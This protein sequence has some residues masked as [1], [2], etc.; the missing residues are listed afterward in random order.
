MNGKRPSILIVEDDRKVLRILT[1][2]L[3]S[4]GYAILQAENGKE[5]EDIAVSNRPDLVIL[6][7][8]LPDYDGIQ[9]LE[10]LMS[11]DNTIKVVILTGYG[12]QEIVRSAMEIGAIDF[13]TK[14]FEPDELSAV[15]REVLVSEPSA[16]R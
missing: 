11:I 16:V 5:A 4:E 7:I 1:R 15:V 14:P 3:S 13:L 8:R 2:Q 6:D 10:H 9:I 12:T